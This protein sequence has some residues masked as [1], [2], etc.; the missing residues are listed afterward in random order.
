MP[1]VAIETARQPDVEALLRAGEAHAREL[2]SE[3][4]CFLLDISE[5][6]RDPVTVFV[7]RLDGDA[8]GM[9]ALVEAGDGSAELKRLFVDDRAR[10]TGV[11]GRLLDAL[12]EHARD[13]GVRVIQLETGTLSL[14]AIALYEKRGYGHIPAFGQYIG[15]ATSVCMEKP[16]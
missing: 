10:G 13:A 4:E 2:Y 16:L 12:E 8:V 9:A 5:L 14:P 6:D 15:S 1:S 7:A 11:A 3:D